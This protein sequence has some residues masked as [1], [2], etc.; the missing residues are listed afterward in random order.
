MSASYL[1]NLLQKIMKVHSRIE[2]LEAGTKQNARMT[3]RLVSSL[4]SFSKKHQE[5]IILL[6]ERAARAEAEASLFQSGRREIDSLRSDVTKLRAQVELLSHSSHSPAVHLP[7]NLASNH[8]NSE[9]S[10]SAPP[11][12][13]TI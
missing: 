6:R 9:A 7:T 11:S 5:E 13:D 1:G 12:R 4:D 10:V 2:Q 3:Q 8:E